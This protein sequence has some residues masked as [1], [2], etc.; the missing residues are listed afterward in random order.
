MATSQEPGGIDSYVM[1]FD[2]LRLMTCLL[3][4]AYSILQNLRPY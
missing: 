3:N 2:F 1:H 4:T